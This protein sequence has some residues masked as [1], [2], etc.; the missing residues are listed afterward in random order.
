MTT[1]SIR[2]IAFMSLLLQ[3]ISIRCPGAV[4]AVRRSGRILE[5]FG[6]DILSDGS[7][8]RLQCRA[9]YQ[10]SV[11]DGAAATEPAL[12]ERQLPVRPEQ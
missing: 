11:A 9:T 5:G 8:E 1:S 3:S 10:V 6:I 4:A 2:K 7:K 12:R